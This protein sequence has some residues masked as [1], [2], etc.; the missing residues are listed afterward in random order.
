MNAASF[1]HDTAIG[2][3]SDHA[4]IALRSA[5]DAIGPN[6]GFLAALALRAAGNAAE[7]E[8]PIAIHTTFLRP[9]THGEVVLSSRLLRRSRRSEA[10]EVAV[11]QDSELVTTSLVRTM[12]SRDGIE[13]DYRTTCPAPD[14]PESFRDLVDL[15]PD[16]AALP[17]IAD[18]LEIR[19]VQT[20]DQWP[21]VAAQDP[22]VS[23]WIRPRIE[24]ATGDPYIDGGIVLVMADLV[25]WPAIEV[26]HLAAPSHFAQT[27]TL[28]LNFLEPLI[29]PGWLYVE[30]RAPWANHGLI[31]CQI[32]IWN[33]R[34]THLVSG[35]ANMVCV[36]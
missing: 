16:G 14:G 12:S 11:E 15:L 7:L 9:P 17:P 22:F 20:W 10:I 27:V 34:G 30:G 35:H 18:A 26:A 28:E 23:S 1:V 3:S 29:R 6:G 19:P 32:E 21:P 4:R 33:E 5:W 31:S 8:R 2:E 24:V 25:T 13:H 36:G